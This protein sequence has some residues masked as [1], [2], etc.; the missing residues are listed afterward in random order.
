MLARDEELRGTHL[1]LVGVR[2][3]EGQV[4]LEGELGQSMEQVRVG[5]CYARG[6]EERGYGADG[7]GSCRGLA[8]VTGVV[9]R[10]T[11]YGYV[12]YYEPCL[13]CGKRASGYWVQVLVR[14][15]HSV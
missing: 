12:L 8:G 3:A 2:C 9:L 13:W 1:L 4:E 11:A 14:T 7:R 5:G 15:V 10:A 6:V